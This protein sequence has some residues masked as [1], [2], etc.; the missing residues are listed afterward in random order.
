MT[1]VKLISKTEVLAITE[2]GLR[3]IKSQE[4][5]AIATLNEKISEAAKQGMSDVAIDGK[6]HSHSSGP[7]MRNNKLLLNAALGDAL[8]ADGYQ[9]SYPHIR[10]KQVTVL[11]SWA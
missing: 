6:L 7:V 9:I 4:A 11:I 3:S 8:K 10:G 5:E 1:D 2:K